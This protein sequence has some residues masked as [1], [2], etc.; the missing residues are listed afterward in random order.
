MKT[1]TLSL[2]LCFAWP[3]LAEKPKS[4]FE[5]EHD[6]KPYRWGLSPDQKW[7]G[8]N[9]SFYRVVDKPNAET[10]NKLDLYTGL[11]IESDGPKRDYPAQARWDATLK[12]QKK[13][14]GIDPDKDAFSDVLTLRDEL[15]DKPKAMKKLDAYYRE[16]LEIRKKEKYD[17]YLPA[18][19]LGWLDNKTTVAVIFADGKE[20][21]DDEQPFVPRPPDAW[22]TVDVKAQSIVLYLPP[23]DSYLQKNRAKIKPIPLITGG[24][25]IKA[26]QAMLKIEEKVFPYPQEGGEL[27]ERWLIWLD[28]M[29]Q[30]EAENNARYRREVDEIQRSNAEKERKE[31]E[32]ELRKLKPEPSVSAAA[33]VQRPVPEAG[34]LGI[35][36][37]ASVLSQP[38]ERFPK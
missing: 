32:E 8:S 27:F 2:L 37:R 9:S 16:F 31:H 12:Y 18:V 3:M 7:F 28:Y 13:V 30:R 6:S 17:I 21:R 5:S 20:E 25:R 4:D 11:G 15:K 35:Q 14:L 22:M 1:L 29:K 38:A 36:A 19:T 33:S 10:D 24:V 26:P 23:G 34:A